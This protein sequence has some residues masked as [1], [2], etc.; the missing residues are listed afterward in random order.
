MTRKRKMNLSWIIGVVS[1]IPGSTRCKIPKLSPKPK[2]KPS[3]PLMMICRQKLNQGSWS[4]LP[5]RWRFNKRNSNS[6][7]FS[8]TNSL[9][10]KHRS[11][12]TVTMRGFS[13]LSRRKRERRR[14]RPRQLMAWW[15]SRMI[16]I[17]LSWRLDRS[18]NNF[19]RVCWTGFQNKAL[20][21]R[22][23]WPSWANWSRIRRKINICIRKGTRQTLTTQPA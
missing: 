14:W 15:K 19:W 7:A 3:Y 22:S 2:L 21:R 10:A 17:R 20:K 1:K 9:R 23:K 16:K 6:K 8:A 4:H 5:A 11:R 18:K 12:N 13:R